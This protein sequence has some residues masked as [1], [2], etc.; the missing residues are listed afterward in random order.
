MGVIEVEIPDFLPMKPLKK[1][2]EDLVKEEEIRWVL[3]RRATEDLDLSNEDLLVLEEVRE[4][5]WKEE[6]K[7]LGL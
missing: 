4:K 2:I 3:F 7:S 1:K 6:K 5:V